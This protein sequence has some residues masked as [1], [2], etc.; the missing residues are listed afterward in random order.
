MLHCRK[1]KDPL[2]SFTSIN[3]GQIP[4]PVPPVKRE[5]ENDPQSASGRRS[6]LPN[7][8]L[9][10]QSVSVARRRRSAGFGLLCGTASFS[11]MTGETEAQTVSQTICV[12]L[13][14]PP[15]PFLLTH[16]CQTV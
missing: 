12:Q 6:A 1:L 7:W 3:M 11:R 10:P 15:P 8:P 13:P 14:P 4:P 5:I 9:Q 2:G 16:C